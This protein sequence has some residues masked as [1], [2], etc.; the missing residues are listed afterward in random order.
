[1]FKRFGETLSA[2][3]SRTGRRF[4]RSSSPVPPVPH[5]AAGTN[6]TLTTEPT[7]QLPTSTTVVPTPSPDTHSYAVPV[8]RVSS[9][10]LVPPL[11]DGGA[12]FHHQP[13]C[14]RISGIPL[15]WSTHD[16]RQALL[17][18]DPELS[19]TDGVQLS[20]PTPACCDYTMT[21]MLNFDQC[22]AYFGSFERNEE[23][24]KV[25]RRHNRQERLVI[26]KHF[27]DLTPL[28]NPRTP[29]AAE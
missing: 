24:Y 14:F 3:T 13:T 16:L 20:K 15:S 21:A 18:I 10:T 8:A 28:S 17:F 7:S 5:G 25:F 1:M 29:I 27:Y 12:S 23:R 2:H 6:S 4:S 11:R 26:D 9:I 19:F 22:T